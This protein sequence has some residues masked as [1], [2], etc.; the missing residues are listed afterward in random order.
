MGDYKARSTGSKPPGRGKTGAPQAIPIL[1]PELKAIVLEL[2][3]ERRRVPNVD[4]LVLTIDGQLIN[5]VLFEYH[6]RKAV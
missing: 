6:F 4:G 5:K 1:T 2:Q 3:A